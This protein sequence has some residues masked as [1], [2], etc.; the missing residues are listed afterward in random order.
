MDIFAHTLW[1]AAAYKK[2]PL[3]FRL[4]AAFFGVAPDLFSF[5]LFFVQKLFSRGVFWGPPEIIQIPQYV[6]MLYNLTHS[7]VIFITIAIILYFIRGRMIPWLIGGWGLHIMIDMF[8]HGR[9]FFPTPWL[10]PISNYTINSFSWS[11][12]WFMILNYSA[13]ISVYTLWY[14]GSRRRVS[15]HL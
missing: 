5:G 3:K 12:P 14:W 8:T 1:T 4:W 11:E 10:W 15:K 2:W 7:L 13:L 6:Y 9:D